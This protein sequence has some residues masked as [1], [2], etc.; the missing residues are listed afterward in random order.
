AQPASPLPSL[1]AAAEGVLAVILNHQCNPHDLPVSP[2]PF[3]GEGPGERALY[4]IGRWPSEQLQLKPHPRC[5]PFP[6]VQRWFACKASDLGASLTEPCL[7]AGGCY[8]MPDN[9]PALQRAPRTAGSGRSD[10]A[11]PYQARG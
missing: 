11:E 2:L 6:S 3:T 4:A 5:F 10:R 9:A 8:G 7:E 1:R